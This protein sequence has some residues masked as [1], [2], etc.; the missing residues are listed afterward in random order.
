MR[1][2]ISILL[3]CLLITSNS[4]ATIKL[5]KGIIRYTPVEDKRVV[6]GKIDC[7]GSIYASKFLKIWM[8]EFKSIYPNIK[9]SF[10]FQGYEQGINALING[11][12]NI[13]TTSRK[14]RVEE[15]KLF[16]EQK[17]YK[18]IE[19]KV[20]LDALAIYVNRLNKVEKI[21][22]GELDAIFSTTLNRGYSQNIVSWKSLGGSDEK[23]N[24]YLLD[25][26][27]G[28]RSYFQDRVMLDG[29]FKIDSVTEDGYTTI[30]EITDRVADDPNGICFGSVGAK[31][32]GVKA[33]SLAKQ[34]HFPSYRP[35]P[36]NIK[37]GK[38]PLTRFIY[39]YLDVPPDKQIPIFLYE[40]C[41]FVLSRDGQ[42]GVLRVGGLPLNPKQIGI[43]LS[44]IKG[45]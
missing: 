24:I 1:G 14:I 12:A 37:N 27:T 35:S 25:R 39:L 11:S 36:Q 16:K 6:Y 4:F 8:R 31:N 21:T 2:I 29:E 44:K 40:F 32:F 22:L 19:V 42:D 13:A 33:L 17:G 38:Y 15:L 20:A 43:E 41:K 18:P 5:S 10:D 3:L 28:T 9:S 34:K 23:I 26:T 30:S 7:K 45:E